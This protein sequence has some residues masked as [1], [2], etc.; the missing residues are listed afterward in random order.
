VRTAISSGFGR[1]FWTIFDANLTSLIAAAILFQFGTGSVQGFA[2][3]LI[4]G[5]L[6][7]MF[8]AIFVSHFLF[9][10][11]YRGQRQVESLSI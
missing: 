1:V 9:D 11:F 3:T 10:V 2:V 7:N 8:T 5:L 4:I 6:S